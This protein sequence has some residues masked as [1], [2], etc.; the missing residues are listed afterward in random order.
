MQF[1][2]SAEH[3]YAQSQLDEAEVS[4]LQVS[5]ETVS[6]AAAWCG[7]L[8][9]VEHDALDNEKTYPAINVPTQRGVKRA[10]EGDWVI[11]QEDGSFEVMGPA[12]YQRSRNG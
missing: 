2:T 8:E 9:V 3:E 5:V 6:T 1:H 12:D 10:S 4:A 11:Q 7:G